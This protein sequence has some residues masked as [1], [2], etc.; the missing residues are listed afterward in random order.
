MTATEQQIADAEGR[1]RAYVAE[2]VKLKRKGDELAQ[3]WRM[4]TCICELNLGQ[5]L[6]EREKLLDGRVQ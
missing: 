6:I 2:I 1:A 5:C 3:F 4:V